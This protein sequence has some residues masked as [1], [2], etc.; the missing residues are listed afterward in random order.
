MCMFHKCDFIDK[1]VDRGDAMPRKN[2]CRQNKRF[3]RIS[4]QIR[5]TSI[6]FLKQGYIRKEVV[7]YINSMELTLPHK[8]NVTP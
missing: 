4:Q 3:K 6:S 5:I 1:L 8:Q 7:V 2:I